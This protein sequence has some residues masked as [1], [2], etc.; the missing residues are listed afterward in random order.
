MT[1]YGNGDSTQEYLLSKIRTGEIASGESYLSTRHSTLSDDHLELKVANIDMD[2]DITTDHKIDAMVTSSNVMTT[3][4]GTKKVLVVRVITGGGTQ[5]PPSSEAKL[6]DKWFGTD[7]DLITNKSQFEACS[8][9][10]LSFEP[11]IGRTTTGVQ[12]NNG[13]YT[14]T[15]NAD[16]L[17]PDQVEDQ[18]RIEGK[19]KLGDLRSQFDHVILSVPNNNEGF[20]AY[21]YVNHWLSL[22]KDRYGDLVTVQMHEIGH[23]LGLAHS[24][25]DDVTYGDTSGLMGAMWDDD[26]NIC[27]NGPKNSQLGWYSDREVIVSN[28]YYGQLYGIA[29]YGGTN[30]DAKMILK[31]PDGNLDFYVTFNRATGVNAGTKEGANQVLVHSRRSGSGYATSLLLAK[32][33]RGQKYIG[34][35]LDIEV[36]WIGAN[37]AVVKIGSRTTR[38]PTKS[39][40]QSPSKSITKSPSRSITKSPTKSPSRSPNKSS[41]DNDQNSAQCYED[42]D[43][44]F[45]KKFKNGK[46]VTA[47]CRSLANL[48]N[49]NKK[50]DFCSKRIIGGGYQTARDTCSVTCNRCPGDCNE[51]GNN[52]FYWMTTNAGKKYKTC[53][54]LQNRKSRWSA[55][56]LTQV[57]NRK[58]PDGEKRI[59]DACPITCGT[60]P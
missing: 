22:Y 21:A 28:Y 6:S 24:G 49:E 29:D 40:T 34:G 5:I 48:T 58:D 60:C 19:A 15:V 2:W 42:P 46:I 14:I 35:P 9:N 10:K 52:S 53:T 43:E 44:R 4:T 16:R 31:V 50:Q 7:G 18:A 41:N 36:P 39:P 45:F 23:N 1:G 27:F 57:C 38:S 54:F 12:I 11:F 30:S 25:E 51:I 13:V 17:Q 26:R 3:V 33:S 55:Q 8:F 37:A 47:S 20:A 32:L 56:Q 59:K